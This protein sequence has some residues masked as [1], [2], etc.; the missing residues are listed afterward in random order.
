M[1]YIISVILINLK[2]KYIIDDEGYYIDDNKSI[3]DQRIVNYIYYIVFYTKLDKNN[4]KNK[5]LKIHKDKEIHDN[6]NMKFKISFEN[7][8]VYLVINNK[9]KLV[10]RLLYIREKIRQL[11]RGKIHG[12]R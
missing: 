3:I 5:V 1:H 9:Y 8:I 6:L 11:V 12:G 10:Y 7:L 4:I 2:I